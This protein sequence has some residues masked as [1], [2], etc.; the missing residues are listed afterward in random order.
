MANEPEM[1]RI[2]RADGDIH[3][4]TGA[5]T[6]GWTDEFLA[7]H[8]NSDAILADVVQ[9]FNGA[10]EDLATLQSEEQVRATVS[11]YLKLQRQKGK[12]ITTRP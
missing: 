6:A 5:A 2:Y 1:L 3:A 9:D 11:K 7:Q 10:Q 4:S 8:K 12:P